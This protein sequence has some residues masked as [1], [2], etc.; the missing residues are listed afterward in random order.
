VQLGERLGRVSHHLAGALVS[1][2]HRRLTPE[3]LQERRVPLHVRVVLLDHGFDLPA[4]VRINAPPKCPTFSC[5]IAHAVSLGEVLLPWWAYRSR[6][7]EIFAWPIK[8]ENAF[9]FTP[10]AIRVSASSGAALRWREVGG[11]PTRLD[12]AFLQE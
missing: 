11:L 12:R 2:V 8:V 1:P 9:A 5:D 4:V 3:Q 6:V 7:I 10:A